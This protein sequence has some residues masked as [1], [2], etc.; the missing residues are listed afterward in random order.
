[1]TDNNLLNMT[2]TVLRTGAE[3]V[4]AYESSKANQLYQK[5]LVDTNISLD[6][7]QNS[8]NPLDSDF[9]ERWN[10]EQRDLQR[11]I[12]RSVDPSLQ[13]GLSQKLNE[14]NGRATL[15][16]Q[17]LQQKARRDFIVNSLSDTMTQL[18]GRAFSAGSIPEYQAV[19]QELNELLD[20]F[21]GNSNTDWEKIVPRSLFVESLNYS[22]AQGLVQNG[23]TQL[24]EEFV[25]EKTLNLQQLQTVRTQINSTNR[26][27]SATNVSTIHNNI[28]SYA[29]LQVENNVPVST[30]QIGQLKFSILR[31]SNNISNADRQNLLG[32]VSALEIRNHVLSRYRNYSH[33]DLQIELQTLQRKAQDGNQE[34]AEQLPY[35][36]EMLNHKAQTVKENPYLEAYNQRK[37]SRPYQ[38]LE[39][40]AQRN[41]TIYN[42]NVDFSNIQ[43]V[44]GD[45]SRFATLE[46]SQVLKE[47]LDNSSPTSRVAIIQ[48]ITESVAPQFLTKAAADLANGNVIL[49]HAIKIAGRPESKAFLDVVMSRWGQQEDL[50]PLSA[51]G[52]T[53]VRRRF[54][55]QVS[56]IVQNPDSARQLQQSIL[57]YLNNVYADDKSNFTTRDFRNDVIPLATGGMKITHNLG[58]FRRLSFLKPHDINTEALALELAS[59]LNTI[60][61][62]RIITPDGNYTQFQVQVAGETIMDGNRARLFNWSDFA[63]CGDEWLSIKQSTLSSTELRE[64]RGFDSRGA[65]VW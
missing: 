46:E 3:V 58:L 13:G 26:N 31:P 1:M 62:L 18:E 15:S 40:G 27:I 43:R 12:V 30:M 49:E 9:V 35:I 55:E 65:S 32:E 34:A 6:N 14:F 4:K 61:P 20:N 42:R 56:P 29:N 63:Y 10:L 16:N 33:N 17:T 60:R 38:P 28:N 50:Y 64:S 5:Y 47:S 44:Y 21:Y 45:N 23:Q 7:Y 54:F 36:R 11:E 25:K 48:R 2:A 39:F 41:E 52:I 8:A 53:K 19:S 37:T 51:E 22:F 59:Q 57:M 24:A